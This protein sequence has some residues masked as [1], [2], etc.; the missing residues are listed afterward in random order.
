MKYTDSFFYGRVNGVYSSDAHQDN[1]SFKVEESD[2]DKIKSLK[3]CIDTSS[4]YE[5]ML[6]WKLEDNPQIKSKEEFSRI[7]VTMQ[8]ISMLADINPE[9]Q[10]LHNLQKHHIGLLRRLYLEFDDDVIGMG[11]KRPFGN[12]NVL[13]D[14][15]EEVR[16]YKSDFNYEED[17]AKYEEESKILVEFT[18][19][20]S[21]F[22]KGGFNLEW[23][24]FVYQ[25]AI[26][27]STALSRMRDGVAE[28]VSINWSK[29]LKSKEFKLHSYLYEWT[30]DPCEIREKK[31]EDIL[32]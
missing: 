32:K 30:L 19:F 15:K 11:Y 29:H 1:I 4:Y 25:S 9:L 17:D 14:V 24:N 22:Y 10:K 21:D 5:P 12:S 13:S 20:L 27:R 6:T 23:R 3:S 28:R 16:R 26:K 2:I 31:I 7:F 18:N 8:F